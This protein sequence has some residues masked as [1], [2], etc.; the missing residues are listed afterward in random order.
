MISKSKKKDPNNFD[1]F[2]A[3]CLK[4]KNQ[5]LAKKKFSHKN[6]NV[7]KIR[8]YQNFQNFWSVNNRLDFLNS[9]FD[10]SVSIVLHH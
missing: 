5:K 8:F 9:E 1:H 2:Y 3:K 4:K 6:L 10:K 7:Q